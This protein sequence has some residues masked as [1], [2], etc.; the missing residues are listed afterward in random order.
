MSTLAYAIP[1]FN[2]GAAHSGLASTLTANVYAKSGMS[3]SPT[4]LATVNSGFLEF[5]ATTGLYSNPAMV[6]LDP[7]TGPWEVI[8]TSSS[9]PTFAIAA[10]LQVSDVAGYLAVNTVL[11][12]SATFTPVTAI[13]FYPLMGVGI[14]NGEV[15]QNF[16]VTQYSARSF[17]WTFLDT[18]GNPISQAGKTVEFVAAQINGLKTI[19]YSTLTTP[20]NISI[21]ANVIT[22]T[23]NPVDTATAQRLTY[24]LWDVTATPN[25]LDLANGSL[26]IQNSVAP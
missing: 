10:D 20:G 15:V 6:N 26:V 11:M 9:A 5:P 25:V 14:F 13:A 17:G 16:T 12:N 1:S 3:G 4:A 22:V 24:T 19:T 8:L 18:A 7:T 2:A 23:F 21:N